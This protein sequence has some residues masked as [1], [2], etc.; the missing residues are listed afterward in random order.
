MEKKT[1]ESDMGERKKE[2]KRKSK[3]WE[4]SLTYH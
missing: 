1:R 2:S 3:N 4:E